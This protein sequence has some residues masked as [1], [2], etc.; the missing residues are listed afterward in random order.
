M[1]WFSYF[2]WT[3]PL[4]QWWS[5]S[6]NW[7]RYNGFI[8]AIS[9]NRCLCFIIRVCTWNWSVCRVCFWGFTFP[10]IYAHLGP[11]LP[12]VI[13]MSYCTVSQV[14][15]CRVMTSVWAFPALL[16]SQNVKRNVWNAAESATLYMWMSDV[17]VVPLDL[18]RRT[19]WPLN[20]LFPQYSLH[21]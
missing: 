1:T 14:S 9:I 20:C 10:G 4:N 15:T 7:C 13:L 8:C 11:N 6:K 18:V 12:N 5:S 2:G 16:S 17:L 21:C 3:N 19:R